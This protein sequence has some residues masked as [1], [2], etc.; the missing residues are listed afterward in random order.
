METQVQQAIQPIQ[1]QASSA[2]QRVEQR[3][4]FQEQQFGQAVKTMR[5]AINQLQASKVQVATSVFWILRG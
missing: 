1:N 2:L 5:D 4:I 3:I